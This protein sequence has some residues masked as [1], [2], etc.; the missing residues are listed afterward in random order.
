MVRTLF[1]RMFEVGG[2]SRGP[3]SEIDVDGQLLES[4]EKKDLI[5]F[6]VRSLCCA[7]QQ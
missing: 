7:E 2:H 1:A 6:H 4:S 3:K 5:F